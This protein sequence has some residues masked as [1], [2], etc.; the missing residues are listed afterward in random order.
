MF[1]GIDGSGKTT[2]SKMMA[3]HLTDQ[4]KEVVWLR[5][6]SASV[7][8]QKIRDL[9]NNEESIPISEELEYFIQDRKWDV[10]TNIE[11]AL[12]QAKSVILDRYFYSTACYQGARGFDAWEILNRNREFAPEPDMVFIIDV[13]VDTAL[14]RIRKNRNVEVKLFEKREFLTKV[15]QNYL[16]LKGEHVHIING[17]QPLQAVFRDVMSIFLKLQIG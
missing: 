3:A 5:E 8:G 11:P 1:E 16:K 9:A 13:D 10:E 15:R 12:R 17:C 6:P 2:I 14:Q 4:G 7:W